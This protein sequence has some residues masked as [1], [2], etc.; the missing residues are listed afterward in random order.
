M[1][2]AEVCYRNGE[3]QVIDELEADSTSQ[4]DAMVVN[5]LAELREVGV[6]MNTVTLRHADATYVYHYNLEN[7][8]VNMETIPRG[9]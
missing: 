6:Q 4:L 1:V 5:K 7:V 9:K 8:I 2:T 3:E